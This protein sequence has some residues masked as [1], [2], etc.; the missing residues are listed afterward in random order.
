L[1]DK[2][3]LINRLG[4]ALESKNVLLTS[5]YKKPEIKAEKIAEELLPLAEIIEPYVCDTLNLFND[6]LK[7]DK[8][9]LLEGQLGALRD[10]DHGIYPYS[11]SSSPTAGFASV[12]AGIPPYKITRIIAVTKAYS[13][14]VGAGPFVS[15]ISGEKA[16]ELRERGGD[17]GEYG[18]TTGRPRRIGWFDAV[19][20]RYGCKVQ[21]ATEVELSLLDVL[22]Y[23]DEIPICVKY[24]L[25]GEQVDD[26]PVS[27]KIDRATPVVKKM[28]GWKTDIKSIRNYTD[29]PDNAKNYIETIEELIDVPIKW[30]SVGPRREEMIQR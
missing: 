12:G 6:A 19:A 5:F 7:A 16:H 8:E 10:P 26:F 1:Y 13:T 2:Q 22:G 29:L 28:P 14:C 9:I 3:R 20:T 17:S 27:A 4:L 24:E 21:G 18:A 15:E 11:T 30:I 25:D 23:L